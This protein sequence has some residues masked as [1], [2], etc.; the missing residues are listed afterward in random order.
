MQ[1]LMTL[2]KYNFILS[3]IFVLA[4]TIIK[5]SLVLSVLRLNNDRP[6]RIG[7]YCIF[8]FLCII[9]TAYFVAMML[10]CTP[11]SA[12]WNFQDPNGKCLAKSKQIIVQSTFNG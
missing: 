2:A 7:L 5:L 8:A 10:S 6:W 12:I 1:N 11:I 9:C 3:Q 4:M